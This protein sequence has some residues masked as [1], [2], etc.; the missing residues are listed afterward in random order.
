[1]CTTDQGIIF[2]V[3]KTINELETIWNNTE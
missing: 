1:L 3:N 2:A